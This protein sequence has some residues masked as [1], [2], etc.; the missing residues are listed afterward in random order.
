MGSGMAIMSDSSIRLKPVIDEPSNPIPSANASSSSSLP[1]ANDFS[2]PRMSVNQKRTNSTFSCSTRASTSPGSAFPFVFAV[3][4]SINAVT[5]SAS[6]A[7]R[8]SSP[9][10][11]VRMRIASST[12]RVKILPSP[13]DPV[14]AWRRIVSVTIPTA[15]SS[16]THSILIFGRRWIAISEP[17]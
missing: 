15:L 16:T 8:T 9:A 1:T 11:P 14:R 4:T 5:P 17:R 7:C 2:W 12:G 10:S 6:W 3:A 13:T